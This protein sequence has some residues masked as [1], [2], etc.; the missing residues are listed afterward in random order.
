M[1]Q[2]D[3]ISSGNSCSWEVTYKYIPDAIYING[4]EII[5]LSNASTLWKPALSIGIW[6][7]FVGNGKSTQPGGPND[8][9]YTLIIAI[10]YLMIF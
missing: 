8:L 4:K 7:Q 9:L 5:Y 3:A 2:M 6:R 1:L 10:T